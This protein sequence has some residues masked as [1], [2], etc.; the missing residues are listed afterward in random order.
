M[1]DFGFPLGYNRLHVYLTR[2]PDRFRAANA[3]L[4]ASAASLR[5]KEQ[6]S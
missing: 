2:A 6:R 5:M 1:T 4:A 3:S